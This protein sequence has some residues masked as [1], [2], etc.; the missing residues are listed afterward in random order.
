MSI[1]I[2]DIERVMTSNDIE[3]EI[4]INGIDHAAMLIAELFIDDN[5]LM[6]GYYQVT[7]SMSD[8]ISLLQAYYL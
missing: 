8:I 4:D 7:I 5:Y 1:Q 6:N 3:I 2:E